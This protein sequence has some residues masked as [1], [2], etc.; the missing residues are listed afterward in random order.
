MLV[1]DNAVKHKGE[2]FLKNPAAI[3]ISVKKLINNTHGIA[4]ESKKITS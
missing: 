4:Y 2:V 1:N 3:P